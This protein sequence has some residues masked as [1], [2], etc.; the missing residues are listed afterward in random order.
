MADY[1]YD[2]YRITLD[3][4]DSSKNTATDIQGYPLTIE[5]DSRWPGLNPDPAKVRADH[6]AMNDLADKIDRMVQQLQGGGSGTPANITSVSSQAKYGPDT[7]FAAKSLK[8]A[9][10]TVAA[11]VAKY[12][13]NLLA[14]LQ[15]ASAAIRQAASNYQQADQTSQQAAQNQNQAL[16]SGSQNQPLN[17]G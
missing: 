7:W 2:D 8:S 4:N 13:Q 15:Q 3:K 6:T 14:N 1:N 12:S 10:D 5:L 17:Y 16:D 9:S 11:T